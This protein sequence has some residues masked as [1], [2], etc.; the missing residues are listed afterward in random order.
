MHFTLTGLNYGE[1]RVCSQCWSKLWGNYWVLVLVHNVRKERFGTCF[2]FRVWCSFIE[3]DASSLALM[4]VHWAW[5]F[6]VDAEAGLLNLMLVHWS[7]WICLDGQLFASQLELNSWRCVAFLLEYL[8]KRWLPWVLRKK[9]VEGLWG[10]SVKVPAPTV[11]LSSHSL[12]VF[13]IKTRRC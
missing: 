11:N 2:L 3:P 13:R 6:L 1:K 12:C 4:V 7:C 8:S 9:I 10:F 5:C